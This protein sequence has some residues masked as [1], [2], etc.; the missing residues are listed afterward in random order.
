MCRDPCNVV[1]TL[2]LEDVPS[3]GPR[4]G[5]ITSGLK[6]PYERRF[7]SP[8]RTVAALRALLGV[9]AKDLAAASGLSQFSLSRLERGH[10]TG[11]PEELAHLFGVL[12]ALPLR[13]PGDLSFPSHDAKASTTA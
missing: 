10:R 6:P 3:A 7:V 11:R 9:S 12:C 5:P 13:S 2:P 8:G 4:G 1:P